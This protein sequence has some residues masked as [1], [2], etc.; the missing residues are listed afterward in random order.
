MPVILRIAIPAC[1]LRREFDYLPPHG[2]DP[3]AAAALEPGCRLR[4]PFGKR[5][6]TAFL[7]EV[8]DH[9]QM[10]SHTLRHADAILDRSSLLS[11][12]IAALCRWAAGYYRTPPGDVWAAAFSR[13]LRDGRQPTLGAWRLTDRGAGLPADALARAPRQRE[14]LA[15]L[16]A[17]A[18]PRESALRAAGIGPAAL[19][20]L[21]RKGLAERCP[22]AAG[23]ARLRHRGP[24]LGSEQ[25]A[26]TAALREALG[27][28]SCHLLEGVTGSGKTEVYLQTMAACLERGE[29]T[30]LL[31]PEIGLTP[32][33]LA[34]FQE[35]ID[36]PIA[37]LHSGRSDGERSDAWDDAARGRAAVVIGTRSAVFTPLARCGAIIVDEEHDPSYRQQDGFRYSARDVAVK[38]AQLEHCPALLGSA[39]PSLESWHN[40][41]EGRYRH[42][43]LTRRAAGAR[44]PT[45]R[46]VDLRRQP[47]RAGLSPALLAATHETLAAGRQVLLFL[48]RRGYATT[49]Q[50]HAC[51][52]LAVCEHCDARLTV[53]RHR[54]RL[55][56]HHCGAAYALPGVCTDCGAAEL[57]TG[58]LGT[59]QTEDYLASALPDWPLH[60]VDSDAIGTPAAMQRLLA[61][62]REGG[63]RILVGTQMLT[64]G[65]HFPEVT[66]VGVIDSDSLLF[67]GD[68]R[69]EERLAQ[70]LTQVAGR[71]GRAGQPGEVLLQTHYPDHPLLRTL[72]AR[73][74]A[75]VADTLLAERISAGMP[76]A[77]QLVMLRADSPRAGEGE[78]FL[79]ALRRHAEAQLPPRSRLIG[80]LPAA[81]PR[82][83][84]RY[85]DQLLCISDDRSAG[86]RAASALVTAGEALR[87][88]QRLHWFIDVDPLDTL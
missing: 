34:R 62:I 29:Q 33:T 63:P 2:V 32:Q 24:A 41:R 69:G 52:W 78:A 9:S 37:L 45:L 11:P 83:A 55:L 73:P 40:A 88:P 77:G 21:A 66:L 61:T 18:A 57:L 80:P 14:A 39:T 12:A 15:A 10:P 47:L 53:H 4:V 38:R 56:C 36:A 84:G 22:A 71:A 48:N 79:G 64:K 74:Y 35:R 85:R 65:H 58:G 49:L 1:P 7:V 17:T 82:R 42:H 54:R 81:L 44:L 51:G 59:E 68:F 13:R 6:V 30:L 72:L 76:P 31:V 23:A 28:F 27:S 26:A 67:S 50:C 19:R 8:S 70:L 87:P 43:R 3:R 60:R 20:A 5:K 25:Q 86:G 16:A 46:A 75:D